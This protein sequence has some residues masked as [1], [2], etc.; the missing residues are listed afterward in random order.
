MTLKCPNCGQ[1][2][3]SEPGKRGMC[4]YCKTEVVFPDGDPMTGE[5]ITCPHCGQNQRYKDGMCINCGKPLLG[6]STHDG[7]AKPYNGNRS[8]I[9]WLIVFLVAVIYCVS[10]LQSAYDSYFKT[11]SDC[12]ASIIITVVSFLILF[13]TSKKAKF[14]KSVSAI[15]VVLI[16]GGAAF[17]GVNEYLDEQR[18]AAVRELYE[19]TINAELEERYSSY[20]DDYSYSGGSSSVSSYVSDDYKLALFMLAQDEV[21]AQL[22]SPSSARFASTYTSSD[23]VYS[24][25]GDTYGVMS[26]VEAENA[27]GVTIRENFTMFATISGGTISDVTCIIGIP[28]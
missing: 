12:I 28:E 25:D 15:L 14:L 2:L 10:Q 20:D 16:L 27:F 9:V 23:V 13:F 6:T 17:V 5:L 24:R 3:K 8:N 11:L 26:W 21:R 4:P 1:L 7:Q 18:A 19:G 22:T